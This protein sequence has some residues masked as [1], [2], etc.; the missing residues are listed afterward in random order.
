MAKSKMVI[1]IDLGT[2]NSCVAY[3]DKSTKR[4]KV[5]ETPEGKN[6]IPSIVCFTDKGILVGEQA[7]RQ[8]VTNPGSTIYRAKCFIG[9]KLNEVPI[10]SIKSVAYKVVPNASGDAWI[11][12]QNKDGNKKY[13]PEEVASK[14]LST[15]KE[16]VSRKLGEDVVDAVITVPA[17]FDDAQR[18]ATRDAA[19]IAG[20][21][22]I[23]II[24]EPT[25]AA[26]AYGI[27][28]MADKVVVA[29]YDLGGGT[30][31]ASILEIENG[32]IQVLATGGDTTLGGELFDE[33]IM[34]YLISEFKKTSGIDLSNDKTALQRLKE[35]SEKAKIELS[36]LE[37]TEVNL[38][39]I[40]ANANGPQHLAISISRGKLESLVKDY[41][42]K[43]ITICKNV[44]NDAKLKAS[45][46][47]EVI[48]V[49]GQTRMPAVQ[50]IA[51][52]AFGKLVDKLNRTLNPD[53]CVALGAAIQGAVM[54]GDTK[55]IVLLDVIPLSLG[56][57]T[58][59]QVFT[60][61]M[62]RNTTIP[63]KKSQIFTTAEDNQPSVHIKV[64]QGERT[65]FDANKLL[66]SFILENIAPAPKG[67]PQIE[68]SFEVDA[69]GILSVSAKD[70]ATGKQQKIIVQA[71]GGLSDA[72]IE[73]MRQDAEAH[74]EEDNKRKEYAQL[75]SRCDSLIAASESSISSNGDQLPSE[76]KENVQ[77]IIKEV[78][79]ILN[80]N[81]FNTLS[82]L[83]SV[84]DK[85]SAESIKI[86]EHMYKNQEE[87]KPCN[88]DAE[89]NT[90]PDGK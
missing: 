25:A 1:G 67:V 74:A 57:E 9:K 37:S 47:S 33:R 11:E 43:T 31:D 16:Y 75:R 71:S 73:R 10:E 19:K 76:L 60:I 36:T 27:D 5:C 23:R 77:N 80:K 12:I 34:Q 42:D 17:Y 45:D 64:A 29:V 44:L 18:Q 35:A 79:E 52:E 66:G 4:P 28:K 54:T 58:L 61:M 59:G 24:N 41:I 70:K 50:K 56:I 63:S 86:G 89:D 68:V 88:A 81:D 62:E 6:T 8:A 85:L 15:I 55:D 26:I 38:P 39:F 13:S 84:Y 14:V 22:P 51:A 83:Q 78:Q 7:K 46:I 49:G 87:C 21:N 30:F 32:V 20:L 65:M 48:L 90:S 53:E 69:N 72:E 2:T 82:D 3:F 40:S